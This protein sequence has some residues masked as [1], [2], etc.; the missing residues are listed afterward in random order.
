MRIWLF[1]FVS[2]PTTNNNLGKNKY[3][4]E[5]KANSFYNNNNIM[6][7]YN[8]YMKS[9]NTKIN[10]LPYQIIKLLIK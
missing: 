4:M 2:K 1:I 9:Q 8:N 5:I 10:T 7:K 6:G 3:D